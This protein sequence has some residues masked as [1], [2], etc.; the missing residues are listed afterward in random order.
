L[1]VK[2]QLCHKDGLPCK[3]TGCFLWSVELC[4]CVEPELKEMAKYITSL[5]EET[6]RKA[7]EFLELNY[8]ILDR[9]N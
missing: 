5:P 1:K 6:Q 4:R 2:N 8:R 3:E 7:R 9:L